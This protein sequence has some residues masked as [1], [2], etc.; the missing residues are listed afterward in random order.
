M[1]DLLI[2]GGFA[3]LI[4]FI[5]IYMIVSIVKSCRAKQ[6]ARNELNEEIM[7][8]GREARE[9]ESKRYARAALAKQ[10]ADR[11]A[12][13]E[14]AAKNQP[15]TYIYADN[16]PTAQTV[17]K[18]DDSFVDNVVTAMVINN[19]MSSHSDTSRSSSRNDDVPYKDT[20]PSYRDESPSYSWG[21]SSSPSSSDS[22]SSWS[23]SDSSPSPSSDW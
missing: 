18:Q 10:D 13:L 23:S 3:S 20:S 14:K 22:S 1:E 4:L 21:S 16:K 6:K 7:R 15:R 5:G 17:A 11:K 2:L 19:I 8:R 9:A 12:E